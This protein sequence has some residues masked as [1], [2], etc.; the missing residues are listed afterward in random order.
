MNKKKITPALLSGMMTISMGTTPISV[1]A[2]EEQP[3]EINK[4]NVEQVNEPV[5]TE[6]TEITVNTDNDSQNT[7]L[8]QP[9][10]AE[11]SNDNNNTKTTTSTETEKEIVKENSISTQA[12]DAPIARNVYSGNGYTWDFNTGILTVTNND[13]VENAMHDVY[14]TYPS[15]MNLKQIVVGSGVTRITYSSWMN[16]LGGAPNLTSYSIDFSQ[17]INLTEIESKA[18]YLPYITGNIDLSNCI[19]L[20]S[21]GDKAF[22]SEKTVNITGCVNLT[23]IGSGFSATSSSVWLTSLSFN[24]KQLDG[25]DRTASVPADY[26]DIADE[27]LTLNAG[28]LSVFNNA[29]ITV[30]NGANIIAIGS[31]GENLTIPLKSGSNTFSLTISW[32]GYTKVYSIIAN[33]TLLPSQIPTPSILSKTGTS[34]TVEPLT[35]TSRYGEAEYSINGKDWQTSNEFTGLTYG[36]Q[37][38]VY[39]RYKGN[40]TYMQSKMGRTTVT[41]KRNGNE[42]VTTPTGLTGFFMQRLYEIELPTGWQWD[43]DNKGLS[44]GENHYDVVFST[45]KY[46]DEYDF[47]NVEGYISNSHYVKRTVTITA[48]KRPTTL[49][50]TTDNMDKPYDG[51]PVSEPNVDKSGSLNDVEFKWFEKIESNWQELSS[52]PTGVGNYKVIASV[53]EDNLYA[54]ETVEREFSIS[55]ATNEWS[56]ELSVEGWTYGKQPKEPT[57]EAKFGIVTFSYSDKKDGT[58]TDTVPTNAGTWYVKATVTGNENYTKLETIKTFEISKAAS[59]VEITT[60]NMDKAYDGNVMAEPEVNKTGSTR[61]VTFTWYVK[62]KE[63]W[64]EISSAPADTGRYKV[65]A[66]VEADNNYNEAKAEKEFSI[67]QTTN[68]WTEELSITGWTHG[69][70]ANEPTAKAK[71]G[72]V[73]F[74]Y[75]DKEDGTYTDTVPTDAGTWY[76]KA[77]VTGSENY[78]GLEKV[79]EFTISKV[80]SSIAFK[81]SFN[82]SKTYDT[83]A[84]VV[85][86]DN[87]EITGSKGKVS[88][89]YEKKTGDG[90]EAMQKAPI[91]AGTYRVTAYLE[92]DTNY[93]AA[94]SETLEFTISKAETLLEIKSDLTQSYNG[95]SVSNPKIEKAGSS[96]EVTITWYEKDGNNWKPLTDAPTDVGTYKVEVHVDGDENHNSAKAEKEFSISQAENVWTEELSVTGWTYGEKE[97]EPTAKAKFGEVIYS[98]SSKEDGTYTEEVPTEAA[99]WYVKATVTGNENYTSLEAIQEFTISKSDSSI[100]FKKDF[101]L[102]KTYD[103]KAVEVTADDVETTGSKGNISFSYEK[104]VGDTWEPLSEAPTGAGTYRVT[105]TLDGDNNYNSATSESLE[106]TIYKANTVLEFTVDD[107]DKV[108]DGKA[109]SAP[110]KQSGN[111]N[112]RVLRWYQ[113][114]EDGTETPLSSAPINAG[115]YRVVATVEAD[116]NFYGAGTEITFE[117]TK[118]VPTYTLPGDLVIKQGETLSSVVLPEGFTW[119]DE[120]QKADTLGTQIFKAVFTPEDTTNYQTVDVDITVDVV[121]ATT[122]V[123]QPPVI[124]AKDQTLTVGDKFDPMKGVTATDKEDGDLTDKIVI[125]KNTVDTSKAGKYTIDYEVTDNGG[126]RV[127][128]TIVVTVKEKAATSDEENKSDTDKKTPSNDTAQTSTQTNVLAWTLL[129]LASAVAFITGVFKRKHQ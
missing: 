55:Q 72:T 43:I 103:T 7:S 125:T 56:E 107:L 129:G 104:K 30:S 25:F 35:E 112:V 119:K 38:T 68:E 37:Y 32:N 88:F 109:A 120:T 16:A 89:T 105:A 9:K 127:R 59:T 74:S 100:K 60:E 101:S 29:R 58:Y 36:T 128:K 4:T 53:A 90:W 19:N 122:P 44:L 110:T 65:V 15:G 12:N 51:N 118:A 95:Q 61:E 114:N 78:T 117:I 5:S 21:I 3:Q 91:D 106:F 77:T 84:V 13:G 121:P 108:Y 47:K 22:W 102:N 52:A 14:H 50:I 23:S 18:L 124:N 20:T 17:A 85:S 111:S 81:D 71:F 48:T 97:N 96:K 45:R 57:A 93:K 73:T 115:K 6:E 31:A 24:G 94:Q 83:K 123:N 64:K 41:T 54:G 10:E 70:Q 98:Y 11:E 39:A 63:N 79:K 113:I 92:G 82:L 75:S 2:Q 8:E 26:G 34:I 86:T 67:S 99:K 1:L 126:T 116:N 69:E 40:N 27:T 80:N 46:E 76:V 42:L 28:V 33:C 87:V 66:S 49:T 62:D